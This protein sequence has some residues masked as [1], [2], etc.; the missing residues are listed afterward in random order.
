MSRRAVLLDALGTLVELE[1]PWPALVGELA[2]RG[3]T[4]S[5][6]EARAA[7]LEEMAYYRAHH[8]EA[9]GT[10]QLDDLR[11]KRPGEVSGGQGQSV[12]GA[13]ALVTGPRGPSADEA[14]GALDP[15]NGARVMGLWDRAALASHAAVG[16]VTS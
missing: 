7:L 16:F 4:V 9:T 11:K 1:A 8:D 13:R 2:A 14:T 10:A 12:A 6:D 5:E 15:L 3:V